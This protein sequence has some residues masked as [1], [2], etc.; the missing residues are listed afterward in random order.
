MSHFRYSIDNF[1]YKN[2]EDY[3]YIEIDGWCYSKTKSPSILKYYINN[4]EFFCDY[5]PIRRS[6]IYS[7]FKKEMDNDFVGFHIR[8]DIME[9]NTFKLIVQD[10]D[11]NTCTLVSKDKNS[12]KKIES[13]NRIEFGIDLIERDESN[14]YKV[15]GW[16]YSIDQKEINLE[17]V[18]ENDDV[19]DISKQFTMRPDLIKL[20]KV[21]EKNAFCGFVITFPI[22]KKKKYFLIFKSQDQLFKYEL[23]DKTENKSRLALDY[24]RAISIENLSKG[25]L[26]LKNNGVKRF[27]YRLKFG[28]SKGLT[29]QDWFFLHRIKE[30]ELDEQKNT[31]FSY[32][33]KI[34]IIVATFNVPEKY[35]KEMMDTVVHQSYSNWELCIADG[36]TNDSVE[37]YIKD[38]YQ[39]DDK[40]KFVKLDNNYGISGNMNK[41]LELATGDYVGLYDHDDMLELDALF[42]IVKSLQ[43]YRYD[44]IYTDEDK[45]D[46]KSRRYVDPNFKPDYNVDLFRSHNYITHFFCVNKRI[47]DIVGGMDSEYDGSQDYDF[48]FRCIEKANSIYHIPKILYHWRMHPLSTAQNPESKMYCY[49]A[50][51]RAIESHYKRTGVKATV[52]MMPKPMYGMYHTIYSTKDNPLV[53]I[54]IPNMNHKKVLKTCI[55]SLFNVNQYK[56]FEIIIIENNSTEKEIFEYYEQIQKEHNNIN[57]VTWNGQFN[58]SAINNFG[59]KYANGEYFLLLNND[60][61]MISKDALSEMVGCCMRSEVGAVGAKLLYED[62]TVQ[63][64]GVIVGFAGYACHPFI[65]I[66]NESNGYM[67]RARINCDYSAVTA[68]CMLVKKSV[69]NEING[70]DEDLKV[71]G[72]DVD[73]CLRIREKGYLIVYNAF[74]LWHHYESKSRGY[75][76][77]PEKVKRFEC[78][79]DLFKSKWKDIIDNGDPY[80]N[81]NLTLTHIPFELKTD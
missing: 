43:D 6:D 24:L 47:I 29:Y 42:E 22:E 13:H 80:Y 77:N 11:G 30:E 20:N 40:I 5:D 35:L 28:P 60:T 21:D 4:N 9:I 15:I 76:D 16:A 19:V 46:D 75:E 49:E 1:I 59:A 39:I 71:A 69:F 50:G 41:A 64:A 38:N 66:K 12:L 2:L 10:I 68:A 8:I 17:I 37:K 23:I 81:K 67:M 70:F 62:N 45:Y 63:H 48:M 44:I 25:F 14:T 26:Y 3:R 74:A 7:K 56:N 52:E 53:S 79:L 57:V 32:S 78:E 65:G 58:Y 61:E 31:V 51:R 54:L 18:D 27:L 33:P 73:L 55:D 34:S 72:N 36:N